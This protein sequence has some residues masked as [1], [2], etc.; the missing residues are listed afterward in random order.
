MIKRNAQQK[1][2]K[3]V[4]NQTDKDGYESLF[5]ILKNLH[6]HLFF[7]FLALLLMIS[8]KYRVR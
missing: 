7:S 4:L 3:L 1:Q 6:F 5:I 8:L 2:N